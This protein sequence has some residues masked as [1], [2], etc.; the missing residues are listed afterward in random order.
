MHA[1]R[2][3]ISYFWITR[4]KNPLKAQRFMR[5]IRFFNFS[6]LFSLMWRPAD[7]HGLPTLFKDI[8]CCKCCWFFLNYT[9]SW[10]SLKAIINN[11]SKLPKF[12]S[13]WHQPVSH[14]E[15]LKI[16]V[17]FS[18]WILILAWSHRF[19]KQISHS[20]CHNVHNR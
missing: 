14:I 7:Q 17:N 12:L 13:I 10:K 9:F 6:Y 8:S 4:L 20:E 11:I 1:L 3:S 5:G 16:V 18:N 15:L 2:K 19:I